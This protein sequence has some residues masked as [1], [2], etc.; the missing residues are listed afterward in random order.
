M[1]REPGAVHATRGHRGRLADDSEHAAVGLQLRQELLRQERRRSGEDDRVVQLV[2]GALR[3]VA[4]F[5]ANVGEGVALEPCLRAGSQ[6]GIDD[7]VI[8]ARATREGA[9]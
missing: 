1:T 4:D 9:R 8:F 5:V 2:A 6:R 7:V 3:P